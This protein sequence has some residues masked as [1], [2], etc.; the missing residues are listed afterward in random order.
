[1]DPGAGTWNKLEGQATSGNLPRC[2]E[3]T[4][5]L[6]YCGQCQLTSRPDLASWWYICSCPCST[7]DGMDWD[8]I[9]RYIWISWYVSWPI[10]FSVL[11]KMITNL[12]GFLRSPT[13]IT[14]PLFSDN[15]CTS[16]LTKGTLSLSF[17]TCLSPQ[18][19]NRTICFIISPVF[20]DEKSLLFIKAS[21]APWTWSDT[22]RFAT[23]QVRSEM[24]SKFFQNLFI[25]YLISPVTH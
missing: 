21:E 23:G 2:T 1:M 3:Q 5:K 10:S 7:S 17:L 11:T 8:R 15:D 14:P 13:S 25:N 22:C 6:D 24:P 16:E 12:Q 20:E 19:Y 18:I 4:L 9:L